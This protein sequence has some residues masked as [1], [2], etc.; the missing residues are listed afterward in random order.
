M[1]L[2]RARKGR[3]LQASCC[4]SGHETSHRRAALFIRSRNVPQT[5][6]SVYQVTKRPTVELLFLRSRNIPQTSY[7]FSGHETSH[8]RAIVSQVT[9][10]P[11]DELLFLRSR[12]VPQTS[13]SFSGH[14]TSHRRA[15]LFIRSRNVR[16]TSSSVYQV[17]KRPTDELLFVRSRNVP[18]TSYCF[19]GHETSH[20][21]AV[22]SQVTKRPTDKLLFLRSRNIPN[23]L[24]G[25][26]VSEQFIHNLMDLRR[27]LSFLSDASPVLQGVNHL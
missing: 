10:R 3:K 14:E 9:T 12:N 25:I 7:C 26:Q 16:Q 21:Q 5:S 13:C 15:V 20:R 8:R 1:R 19:S 4:F 22:L 27:A 24:E 18:Q 23:I 11:T 2:C 17:T 6:C